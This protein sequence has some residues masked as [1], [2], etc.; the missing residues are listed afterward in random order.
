L[1]LSVFESESDQK[2]KNKY[3]INDIRPYPI[4]FHPY[5]HAITL[6]SSSKYT[7]GTGSGSAVHHMHTRSQAGIFKPN[8]R[9]ALNTCQDS[10]TPVIS[11]IPSTTRAAF[12]D[13]NWRAAMALEFEALQ[14]NRT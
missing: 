1:T 4:C 3:D 5:T 12:K 14:R 7:S 2:Y 10:S 11:P 8:P 13:Q 6:P 9:Y